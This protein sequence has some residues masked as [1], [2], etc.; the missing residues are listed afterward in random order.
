MMHRPV[1]RHK[2][3][4][5]ALTGGLVPAFVEGGSKA[6]VELSLPWRDSVRQARPWPSAVG[7]AIFRLDTSGFAPPSA[8]LT[9]LPTLRAG[10]NG[11]AWDRTRDLPRVKRALSR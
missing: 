3:E 10:K 5:R 9:F 2:R 6:L 1:T 7:F 4:F 8:A 11:R